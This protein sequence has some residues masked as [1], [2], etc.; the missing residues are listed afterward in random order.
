MENQNQQVVNKVESEAFDY[1]N[2]SDPEFL[3][4]NNEFYSP[5]CIVDKTYMCFFNNI[6]IDDNK[7]NENQLLSSE[8]PN[9][10]Q[11]FLVKSAPTSKANNH[12]AKFRYPRVYPQPNLIVDD[13][14]KQQKL[15]SVLRTLN[16]VLTRD[17]LDVWNQLAERDL[18]VSENYSSGIPKLKL[19]ISYKIKQ[20]KVS[21]S[22]E[23]IC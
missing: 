3:D 6:V 18:A 11:S 15:D 14:S 4:N 7:S 5:I 19:C 21:K 16:Q 23:I 10:T 20:F 2:F 13:R 9:Q 17:Q 1:E 12:L 22:K 8:G